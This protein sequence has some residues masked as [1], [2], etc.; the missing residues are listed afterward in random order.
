MYLLCLKVCNVDED[1]QFVFVEV[2]LF[3]GVVDV[4]INCVGNGVILVNFF[5]GDFLF[6]V[7]FFVVYCYYGVKCSIVG[8][9]EFFG[10]F[11]GFL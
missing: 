10:V 11:D 9:V 4:I 2:F 6:I 7:G 1:F 3:V 5:K 8:E